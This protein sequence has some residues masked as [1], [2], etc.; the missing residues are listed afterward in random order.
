ML[1][2][3]PIKFKEAVKNSIHQ[4]KYIAHCVEDGKIQ[5]VNYSGDQ[6]SIILIGPE[7]GFTN[8]EVELAQQNKFVSVSLGE[9]R[10][11]TETAGIV[12]AVFLNQK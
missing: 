2:Q 5:L 4:N 7:G 8:D 6:S 3:E 11:R 10:L 1:L 9:T 12:A